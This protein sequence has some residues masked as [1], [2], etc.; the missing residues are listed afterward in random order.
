MK[1]FSLLLICLGLLFAPLITL[2][3]SPQEPTEAATED[4]KPVVDKTKNK[5]PEA[6]KDFYKQTNTIFNL[7][8]KLDGADET[9]RQDALS[10]LVEVGPSVIP[11][12][13]DR[14]KDKSIY[15][16]LTRQIMERHPGTEIKITPKLLKELSARAPKN[17][18]IL[19]DKY[20]YSKYLE[21]QELARR[22][23][24]EEAIK[25]V[26]SILVIEP[27]L[28]FGTKLKKF[29]IDCEEKLIKEKVIRTSLR[30]DKEI[31]ETGDKINFSLGFENVTMAP[32]AITLGK[33]NPAVLY[34]SVTEYGPTGSYN[35]FD[36]MEKVE[37]PDEKIVLKPQEK[38][39]YTF[40]LDTAKDPRSLNY[41]TY[42]LGVE[43]RPLR[44]EGVGDLT[45]IRKIVFPQV[46][47]KTFP[48]D[49]EPVLKNP[50]PKLSQALDGGMPLDI[51]LCAL[52]V[53]P[54]DQDKAVALLMNALQKSDESIKKVLM[55]S[56][57]H[58]TQLPFLQ[59]ETDW[60][61]WWREKNK[62]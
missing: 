16:E 30:A 45:N 7:L 47:V 51:F 42:T 33:K 8:T 23:R 13:I 15:V 58:V 44:I 53:P 38:W 22:E 39:E 59:E 2:A 54:E 25:M 18:S 32:I 5:K 3:D 17:E 20:L 49:V 1:F 28:S 56:L 26:S 9:D 21:A 36:R 48:P 31:H 52:L 40:E 4:K 35:N 61:E 46:T 34:L 41:R 62:N 50:L 10:Q 14:L 19:T 6:T 57:K 55:N 29:R 27:R 11:F 12:L 24:Y 43:I 60:L 37:L